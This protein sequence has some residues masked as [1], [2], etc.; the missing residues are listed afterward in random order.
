MS[1]DR[2]ELTREELEGQD[3]ERLP[4]RE[5]MSTID[6]DGGFILCGT[7]SVPIK[8]EEIVVDDPHPVS[9]ET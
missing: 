8:T 2:N 6:P 4:Q 7:P 9:T 3:G 1:D 5:V